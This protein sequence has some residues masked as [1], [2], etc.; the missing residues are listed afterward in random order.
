MPSTVVG[1][2][3][4]INWAFNWSPCSLSLTHQPSASSH[5][6]AVTVGRDPTTV[7]SSRCPLTFTRS[8]QK[9]FSSLWKVTRSIKPETS[10]VLDVSGPL[11]FIWSGIH[12]PTA[13]S[14]MTPTSAPRSAVCPE[15]RQETAQ[16]DGGGSL[17]RYHWLSCGWLS[18]VLVEDRIEGRDEQVSVCVGE[19]QRGAELN[20]VVKRT[21]RPRK[22]SALP[23]TVADIRSLLGCCL[24]RCA[25]PHQIQTEKEPGAT[26][27]AN[28]RVPLAQLFQPAEQAV[29]N[30]KSILLQLLFF[31]Y[32]Q[33]R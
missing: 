11:A 1:G 12:C 21:I 9:P 4:F 20:H 32:V 25:L 30:A 14:A 31:E 22:D 7:T 33:Y 23:E 19:H 24:T 10:S 29:A 15:S 13:F 17:L 18:W 16:P 6:P 5:S 26:D 8:T 2:T 28:Q 3:V 27:I